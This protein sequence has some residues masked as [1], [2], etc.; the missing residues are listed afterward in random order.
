MLG[1]LGCKYNLQTGGGYSNEHTYSEE[2]KE[3]LWEGLPALKH[4]LQTSCGPSSVNFAQWLGSYESPLG[5]CKH[6]QILPRGP[7][8]QMYSYRNG[9]DSSNLARELL[10]KV[11]PFNCTK[12]FGDSSHPCMG[13]SDLKVIKYDAP[14]LSIPAAAIK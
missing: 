4:T 3:A 6:A 10:S 8:F 1:K 2:Q 14:L 7:R 11:P 12:A 5:H 13:R 9:F